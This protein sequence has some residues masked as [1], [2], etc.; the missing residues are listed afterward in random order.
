MQERD[1]VTYCG[2]ETCEYC[3]AHDGV[4]DTYLLDVVECGNVSCILVIDAVSRVDSELERSGIC[5]S[6]THAEQMPAQ[7]LL[8]SSVREF[9]G[10]N[11]DDVC[12][13]L[14]C[15]FNLTIDGIN[16]QTDFNVMRMKPRNGTRDRLGLCGNIETTFRCQFLTPFGY[17]CH[18]LRHGFDRN[19]H[20][21]IGHGH[22]HVQLG[23]HRVTKQAKIAI[24][25]M[26][27]ILTQMA[28]DS[29]RTSQFTEC[30]SSD[31]IGF[32][33]TTRFAQRGD[34][35]YVDAEAHGQRAGSDWIRMWYRD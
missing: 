23:F 4:A 6:I 27:T 24:V 11:F 21:L 9:A 3:T 33:S 10:M 20:D 5:C 26:S 2:I 29:L 18:E 7:F 17:K 25:D 22:F 8:A 15:S 12:A 1:H 31:G 28:D 32:E 34:M 14:S 35:I 13:S 30:C 16:E 19:L